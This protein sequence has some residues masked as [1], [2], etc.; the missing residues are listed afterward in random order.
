MS[1]VEPRDYIVLTGTKELLDHIE[2]KQDLNV[3]WT[4]GILPKENA[5]KGC[6]TCITHCY[7]S[8]VIE[9]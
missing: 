4:E 9:Q 5:G 3:P 1:A 8:M 6:G 2:W 7:D